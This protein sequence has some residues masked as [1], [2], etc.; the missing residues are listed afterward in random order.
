MKIKNKKYLRIG[1]GILATL[2][3]SYFIKIPIES[4]T[5]Y[6]ISDS[7]L[8]IIIFHNLYILITYSLIAI[9]FINK[10]TKWKKKYS[11]GKKYSETGNILQSQ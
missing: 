3:L 6:V 4:G 1:I 2:I 9:Y 8:G 5:N 10:S 7:I 11:F